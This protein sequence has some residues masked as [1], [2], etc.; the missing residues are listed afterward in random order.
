MNAITA[1][2]LDEFVHLQYL[3]TAGVPK[4]D[5]L[6][7]SKVWSV[8]VLDALWPH[9]GTGSA[10]R[11]A[12]LALAARANESVAS[13]QSTPAETRRSLG[14]T[15]APKP[16]LLPKP[17]HLQ[18]ASSPS[19][20]RLPTWTSTPVRTVSGETAARTRLRA[21]S[22]AVM[23]ATRLAGTRTVRDRSAVFAPTEPLEL[24]APTP[25]GHR[26][27]TD[28]AGMRS[29]VVATSPSPSVHVASSGPPH[30]VRG[31]PAKRRGAPPPP[32]HVVRGS[33]TTRRRAPPPPPPPPADYGTAPIR[34]AGTTSD[35]LAAVHEGSVKLKSQLLLSSSFAGGSVSSPS[36]TLPRFH[37]SSTP[38]RA[39]QPRGGAVSGAHHFTATAAAATERGGE[40]KTQTCVIC[41]EPR[42][43]WQYL[44]RHSQLNELCQDCVTVCAFCCASQVRAQ[45]G[46]PELAFIA[47]MFSNADCQWAIP[48][49][50]QI[51][52]QTTCYATG[53][54]RG[55][56]HEL[57]GEEVAVF[58]RLQRVSRYVSDPNFRWCATPDCGD[59]LIMPPA[60]DPRLECTT[61]GNHTCFNHEHD[62]PGRTCAQVNQAEAAAAAA[63]PIVLDTAVD[64]TKSCPRCRIPI[65]KNGGCMH[66]TCL[67]GHD[68]FWCCLR[69]YRDADEAR[70]HRQNCVY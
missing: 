27:N 11:S 52:Q 6:A 7:S 63:T 35:G 22:N 34:T 47:C 44:P 21:L 15:L 29:K 56:P 59:A 23:K 20:S 42:P 37:T 24:I 50:Q 69:A 32:P 58:M 39:I 10:S 17:T 43:T 16:R 55:E 33:P 67:C 46:R 38:N 65:E 60:G 25:P 4:T 9:D 53:G 14:P 68:F 54:S 31:S 40:P 48:Q 8:T 51:H 64:S 66:M 13:S 41:D 12:F 26:R 62:H 57:T 3:I 70:A 18:G 36:S 49:V 19:R 45:L 1:V 5:I 2:E 30:A 61:C 28:Q